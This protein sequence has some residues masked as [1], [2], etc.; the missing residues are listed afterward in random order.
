MATLAELA[1]RSQSPKYLFGK[2]ARL[3]EA[4]ELRDVAPEVLKEAITEVAE[5][6]A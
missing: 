1:D 6:A 3:A 2:T 5:L 4:L